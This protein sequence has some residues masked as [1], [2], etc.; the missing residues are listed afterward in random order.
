MRGFLSI[1]SNIAVTRETLIKQESMLANLD[2]SI[3]EWTAKLEKI[4]GRQWRIQQKLSQHM[5]A[6]LLLQVPGSETRRISEEQTPPRSPERL[7]VDWDLEESIDE[8]GIERE[9]RRDDVESI[10]IYA[11]SGV[12][13]GVAS[14]LKSIEQEIDLM[15]QRR[16]HSPV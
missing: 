13:L 5:A 16:N 3:D 11:G 2:L 14:L 8:T 12:S 10:R 7:V 15:G 1:S 4:E 9:T 6:V